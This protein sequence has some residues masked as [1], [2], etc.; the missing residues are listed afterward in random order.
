MVCPR[1]GSENVDV[2]LVQRYNGSITRSFGDTGY[3][4]KIKNGKEKGKINAVS[5]SRT[6]NRVSEESV[7]ICQN[8]GNLWYPNRNHFLLKCI[9]VACAAL[10]FFILAGSYSAIIIASFVF[11]FVIFMIAKSLSV[12]YAEVH[13]SDVISEKELM[14]ISCDLVNFFKHRNLL[15]MYLTNMSR[16]EFLIGRKNP[17]QDK[18]SVMLNNMRENQTS[19]IESALDR[20]YENFKSLTIQSHSSF[21]RAFE[22]D[23]EKCLE[24]LSRQNIEYAGK[25]IASLERIYRDILNQEE[26]IG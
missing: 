4:G 1:C 14:D 11:L 22:E 24:Y 5:V 9:L 26:G 8:C 21:A 13:K 16:V 18:P 20:A 15:L 17:L 10:L 3:K 7:C 12:Q 6:T 2:Q 23:I 25:Y 19:D